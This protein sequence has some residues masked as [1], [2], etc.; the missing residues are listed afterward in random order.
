MKQVPK[1]PLGVKPKFIWVQHRVNEIICAMDRHRQFNQDGNS[2]IDWE[3]FS[4]WS[5]E[6]KEHVDFLK[7]RQEKGE[8][9]D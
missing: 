7:N 1:P 2:V 5:D 6:L 3:R 9:D 4:R 8:K